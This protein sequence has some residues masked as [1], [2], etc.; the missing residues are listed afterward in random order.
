MTDRDS[1]V[2]LMRTW[3]DGEAEIVRGLLASYGIPCQVV[4]DIP[5]SVSPLTVDGLGEIRIFVPPSARDR[6]VEVL[7][8]HRKP[9]SDAS[10]SGNGGSAP[11]GSPDE[12]PE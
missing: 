4:S 10:G 11:A 7:A 9:G 8:E 5:H 6:A 2:L 3:D 1:G 12:G